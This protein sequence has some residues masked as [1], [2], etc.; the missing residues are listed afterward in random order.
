MSDAHTDLVQVVT[1]TH[2]A[3]LHS[4]YVDAT[5]LKRRDRREPGRRRKEEAD[6]D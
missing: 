3:L 6:N 1:L 5:A 4:G 2:K